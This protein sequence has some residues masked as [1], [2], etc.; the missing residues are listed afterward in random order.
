MEKDTTAVCKHCKRKIRKVDDKWEYIEE[1]SKYLIKTEHD[2]EPV[3]CT[4]NETEVGSK[5]PAI[6]CETCGT[7]ITFD[8]RKK[9]WDHIQNVT[10][11]DIKPIMIGFPVTSLGR[12]I[13]CDDNV[14]ELL[15]GIDDDKRGWFHIDNECEVENIEPYNVINVTKG[16]GDEITDDLPEDL[17]EEDDDDDDSKE[18]MEM[19][20]GLVDD[21]PGIDD[22]EYD[23]H[24]G[25]PFDAGIYICKNRSTD[26]EFNVSLKVEGE[27]PFLSWRAWDMVNDK[28]IKGVG[29]PDFHGYVQVD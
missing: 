16:S 20:A 26:V 8:K 14:V 23:L 27:A 1:P 10:C 6:E 21:Y 19:P 17:P 13:E 28:V 11:T 12:C 29:K 2:P 22:E 25:T 24:D 18:I 15:L 9:V 7:E 3:E 4:I 5:Q